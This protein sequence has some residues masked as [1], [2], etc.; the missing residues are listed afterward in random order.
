MSIEESRR[1][2]VD[3]RKTAERDIAQAPSSSAG[4][5]SAILYVGDQLGRVAEMIQKSSVEHAEKMSIS[6]WRNR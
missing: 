3:S 5:A 4:I 1:Q 6:A 2:V